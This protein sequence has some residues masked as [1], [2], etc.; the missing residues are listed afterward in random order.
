MVLLASILPP[1]G[2]GQPEAPREPTVRP[3]LQPR[4]RGGAVRRCRQHGATGSGPGGASFAD[5]IAANWMRK[6]RPREGREVTWDRKD[7]VAGPGGTRTWVASQLRPLLSLSTGDTQDGYG[8][9]YCV[10]TKGSQECSGRDSLTG[11]AGAP[12]LAIAPVSLQDAVSHD[13]GF[14]KHLPGTEA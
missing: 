9:R 13:T 12:A 14:L 4:G 8:T 2:L 3:T 7:S 10:L 1:R 5:T 11:Q 6:Q